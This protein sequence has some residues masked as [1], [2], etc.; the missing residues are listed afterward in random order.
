MLELKNI[1]KIYNQGKPNEFQALNDVSLK[2]EDGEM[3][4]IIGKSGAGKSTMLHIL[5]GIDSFESGSY[6]VG[7]LSIGGLSDRNLAKFRNQKVGMV[8]QDF[9]LVE[10]YTVY[11]NI[12]IPLI[13]GKVKKKEQKQRIHGVL[14]KLGILDKSDKPVN[15]LS[16]GQKQRVAIAR[17]IVNKPEFILADE[18]TGALD[19]NTSKE[20]MK[21]FCQL[22]EEG[23]TVVIVTHDMEIA[24][25]CGRI[26]EIGDGRIVSA[27]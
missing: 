21:V 12:M 10:E 25:Q 1:N 6:Q 5:A 15:Q 23:H 2:I 26:I 17:A 22:N 18:P 3:V 9:A 19:S 14:E 11:E 13:F 16:G 27:G 24:E 4:A 20:I 8:M 7:K